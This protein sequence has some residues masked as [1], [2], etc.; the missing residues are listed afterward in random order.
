VADIAF[1]PAGI[2]A[3]RA[4]LQRQVATTLFVMMQPADFAALAT[5]L[6]MPRPSLA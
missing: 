4:S 2:G 5:P 3:Q 1:D 6:T